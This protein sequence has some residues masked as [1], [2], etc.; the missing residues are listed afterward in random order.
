MALNAICPSGVT[1]GHPRFDPRATGEFSP[2]ALLFLFDL[3]RS[4]TGVMISVNSK[5]GKYFLI[6]FFL[7]RALKG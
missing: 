5:G 1:G 6:N 3:T 7:P 4:F 2:V